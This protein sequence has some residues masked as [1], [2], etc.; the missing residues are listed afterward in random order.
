M[1]FA[2]STAAA[3]RP[4]ASPAFAPRFVQN[5]DIEC[6]RRGQGRR[7]RRKRQPALCVEAEGVILELLA[8]L[9][10]REL[11]PQGRDDVVREGLGF[12][13]GFVLGERLV[14]PQRVDSREGQRHDRQHN[15]R[16][17]GRSG[18]DAGV[19]FSSRDGGGHLLAKNRRQV[20]PE[21][22]GFV[23]RASRILR[24]NSNGIQSLSRGGEARATLGNR[25]KNISTPTRLHQRA[26]CVVISGQR[27][28]THR[29]PRVA[30]PDSATLG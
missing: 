5:A 8:R 29:T 25:M 4:R 3:S 26:C 6:L 23:K 24:R 18:A 11:C 14:L 17:A 10:V 21:C 13:S 12:F 9:R 15:A 16:L 30:S 7:G 28:S 2:G 1:A 19:V 20:E 27:A 22:H